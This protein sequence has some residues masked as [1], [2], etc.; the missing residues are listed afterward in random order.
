ME[1]AI[2]IVIFIIGS[3]KIFFVPFQNKVVQLRYENE[4]NEKQ[5]NTRQRVSDNIPTEIEEQI[6]QI[7]K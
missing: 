4:L 1:I 2:C 6:K 5:Q 7:G 3:W